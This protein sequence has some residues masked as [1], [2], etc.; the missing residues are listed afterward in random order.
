MMVFLASRWGWF[1]T[2]GFVGPNYESLLVQN[3]SVEKGS[4]VWRAPGH[5]L[6]EGQ[7]VWLQGA[8]PAGSPALENEPAYLVS[9]QDKDN[10]QLLSEA[11]APAIQ[12]QANAARVVLHRHTSLPEKAKDLAWHTV[13]P[14]ISYLVGSFAFVTMLM[15]NHLMDNLS[16]DYMR[17]AIA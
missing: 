11:G 3:V 6:S 9:V 5:G 13:L 14:L 16:A 17:T 4:D 1:P 7:E 10:F 15:K 12:L 8:V 2:G